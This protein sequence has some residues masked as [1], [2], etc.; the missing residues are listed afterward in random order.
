MKNSRQSCYHRYM[1]KLSIFI[2]LLVGVLAYFVYL[3][4]KKNTETPVETNTTAL[5]VETETEPIIDGNYCFRY[6]EKTNQ[7]HSFEN[8]SLSIDGSQVTGSLNGSTQSPEYS[9]G[10]TGDLEG[11]I[12]EDGTIDVVYTYTIEGNIQREERRYVW[13]EGSLTELEYLLI[14]DFQNDI[15]RIDVETTTSDDGRTFPREKSLLARDCETSD[16]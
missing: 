11:T 2:I 10:Y 3:D 1:K 9:T 7:R 8:I 5:L 14:E 6:E 4:Q 15:L 16:I 13:K 12:S